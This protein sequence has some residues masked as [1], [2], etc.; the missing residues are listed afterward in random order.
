[1]DKFTLDL[2]GLQ[3]TRVDATWW[4]PV[5]VRGPWRGGWGTVTRVWVN[6]RHK[7]LHSEDTPGSSRGQRTKRGSSMSCRGQV[8]GVDTRTAWPL[9]FYHDRRL[10]RSLHVK[11]AIDA[12]CD[13]ICRT[14][15]NRN[16]FKFQLSL[17][18]EFELSGLFAQVSFI[19]EA[20][21]HLIDAKVGCSCC[22]FCQRGYVY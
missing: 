2:G 9:P 10:L 16:D 21:E 8:V 17:T 11:S 7:S 14:Y 4:V 6:V 19:K 15:I 1:M 3:S 12:S 5:E 18:R 13:V 20:V 22:C